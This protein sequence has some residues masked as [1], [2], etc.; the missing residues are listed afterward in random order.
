MKTYDFFMQQ[1]ML[2]IAVKMLKEKSLLEHAALG[3]GTA[4]AGKYWNHRFSTDIDIFIYKNDVGTKDLLT[5]HNWSEEIKKEMQTLG[6]N[7]DMK[8]QNIYLEFTITQESKMQFF[9][10][11]GFTE[12]PF[13]QES[14][15]EHEKINIETPEEI[16]AKKIYYRSGKGNSR[17]I[18]DIAVALQKDPLIF[19][20][21]TTIPI[22]T[23]EELLSTIEN[24]T[25]NDTLRKTFLKD[26]MDISPNNDY[27]KIAYCSVDYLK[28]MVENYVGSLSHHIEL[29][30]N[31]FR[32]FSS[33]AFKEA[34]EISKD[35]TWMLIDDITK[36]LAEKTSSVSEIQELT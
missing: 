31:D 23:Y 4:L 33:E 5:H 27:D 8:W 34:Q 21:L 3:G 15:W 17:D 28:I 22:E 18:F 10:V 16:I 2:N 11:K 12:N 26:I 30:D 7:S 29:S 35:Y 36:E 14:L 19:K 13:T 9:D 32:M 6:Y 25:T 20:K 1:K 24:I